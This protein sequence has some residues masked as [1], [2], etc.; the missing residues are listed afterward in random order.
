VKKV[1]YIVPLFLLLAL[2]ELNFAQCAMCKAVVETA[3]QE[4]NEIIEGVNNG[5]LYMMG[6]PYLLMIVVGFAWY[7]RYHKGTEEN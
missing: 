5:I 1:V 2:P 4:G 3:S 7:K 6:V